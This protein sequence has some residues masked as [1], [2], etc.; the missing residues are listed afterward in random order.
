MI[1]LQSQWLLIYPFDLTPCSVHQLWQ[2]TAIRGRKR[3]QLRIRGDIAPT[4]NVLVTCCKEDPDVIL[5]TVRAACVVDYPRDRFRV[6]VCDDGAD[7]DL[8]A[9][10]KAM[11]EMFPNLYYHARV[12]VKG[13]PHHFKAGNLIA[14]TEFVASLEGG[15]AEFLAA[16]DADMIPEHDWL[17]AIMA[18]L[19]VDPK[20]A[21]SCPPQVSRDMAVA[22]TIYLTDITT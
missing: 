3:P 19:C 15:P 6:T 1:R 10:V 7:P 4:V 5:D 22:G 18:P 9:G 16:L 8:K 14:A 13:V 12:K 11:K 17:S 2:L 20:M 21:L